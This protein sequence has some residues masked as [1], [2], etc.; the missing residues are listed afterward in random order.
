VVEVVD[1]LDCVLVVVLVEVEGVTLTFTAYV[2]ATGSVFHVAVNDAD[3]DAV[4]VSVPVG[5]VKVAV[6]EDRLQVIT[7]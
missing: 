1:V 5:V 2:P 3:E 7:L 6:T 4:F